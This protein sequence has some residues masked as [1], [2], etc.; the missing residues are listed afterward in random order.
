M[1]KNTNIRYVVGDLLEDDAEA[2]VNAVN[3]VG[4]MGAGIAL[5]FKQKFPNN[6]LAY[7]KACDEGKV[8][9]GVMYVFHFNEMFDDRYIINFPTKDH[10]KELSKIEYINNGLIDLKWF[11]LEN[12][13]NSIAIPPLGCGLGG[14]DWEV[15]KLKI[16]QTFEDINVDVRVYQPL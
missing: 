12:N 16:E 10:W 6:F 15:V 8:V 3:C 5:Q 13:I 9:P 7:K 4:V 11:V 14:L 1:S 2:I